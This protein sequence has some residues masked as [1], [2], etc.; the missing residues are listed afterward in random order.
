[1]VSTL[2]KMPSICIPRVSPNVTKSQILKIFQKL[3][4]GKIEKVDIVSKKGHKG[5]DFK[6]IFLH[7]HCWNDHDFATSTRER[8][9]SGKDIKIVYD[10]PWFWKA[11]ALKTTMCK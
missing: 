3:D 9:L 11:S 10:F 2:N 5:E 7:F 4:F 6:R 8:L 1:M